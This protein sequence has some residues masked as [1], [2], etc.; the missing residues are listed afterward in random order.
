MSFADPQSITIGA[1]TIS[2][3]RVSVG[4]GQSKY[5][6]GDGLT[7]LTSSSAYG[8]RIRRVLRVDTAKI[9]SDP[10]IPANNR[11]ESMSY[12]MVF[13]LPEVGYDATAAL[14]VAVGLNSLA[15]ASSNA[16][17]KKLLGGES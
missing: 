2:L 12:Y 1:S 14:D 9:T 17:L 8:R 16:I 11:K 7:T 5:T 3:P 4:D 15:S 13:D 10:F 6:S